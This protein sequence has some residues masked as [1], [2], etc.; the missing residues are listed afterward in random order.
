MN[1]IERLMPLGTNSTHF[2]T[3]CGCAICSDE[4][5]CPSCGEPVIGYDQPTAHARE[6][7]RWHY[8]TALWGRK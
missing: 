8:A 4:P 5:N 1:Y 3:C 7:V 2:T 6:M